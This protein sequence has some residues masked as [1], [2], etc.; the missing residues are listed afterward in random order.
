M[1]KKPSMGGQAV[2]EGVMMRGVDRT[3]LAVRLPDGKILVKKTAYLAPAKKNRIL[4][5]PLIRGVCSLVDSL[6][7]GYETLGD[8]AA[9]LGEEEEEPSKFEKWLAKVTG[10][11]VEDIL[12]PF[13][14]ILGLL[15]A[16][17]LF[18]VLPSLAASLFKLFIKE[19]ILVNLLEGAVRILIFLIYLLLVRRIPDMKRI[20][21]YHGAEHKTVY[22]YEKDL[23]LTTENAAGFSC[24]H[25]RCGTAFLLIVMLISILLFSVLGWDKN[26]FTRIVSRLLL[27]PLVAGVSYE[28]LRYFGSHEN[29]LVRILRAPGLWMQKLTTAEPDAAM[30]QVAICAMKAALPGEG[31]TEGTVILSKDGEILEEE[32]ETAPQEE[33]DALQKESGQ[34]EKPEERKGNKQEE[35]LERAEESRQTADFI[36]EKE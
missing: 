17:G 24:L 34:E 11:K 28:V 2:L 18:F 9:L 35:T 21:R 16:V 25:P 29:F 26:W 19:K 3:A 20:F 22:C 7:T 30:L 4:G 8:S 23:P 1:N 32:Q 27:L 15:L 14:M 10:K 13:A 5:F 31:W 36:E 33:Q 12:M 6:K